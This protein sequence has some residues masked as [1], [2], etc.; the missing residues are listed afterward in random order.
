MCPLLGQSWHLLQAYLNMN[1]VETK[2]FSTFTWWDLIILCVSLGICYTIFDLGF[3]FD[4]AWWVIWAKT[5]SSLFNKKKKKI[6]LN[7][8]NGLLVV[9]LIIYCICKQFSLIGTIYYWFTHL[10]S[11][12]KKWRGYIPTFCRLTKYTVSYTVSETY[13]YLYLSQYYNNNIF[14]LCIDYIRY[15]KYISLSFWLILISCTSLL[16]GSWQR[17][18][19]LCGPI[20]VLAWPSLCLWWELPGECLL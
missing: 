8:L 14:L 11:F 13:P 7:E 17:R 18:L 4:V 1:V 9:L 16:P 15:S 5:H 3:R 6:I 12:G 10:T 20:W 2:T 19:P